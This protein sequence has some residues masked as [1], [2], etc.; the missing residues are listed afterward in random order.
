MPKNEKTE[1]LLVIPHPTNYIDIDMSE[2]EIEKEVRHQIVNALQPVLGEFKITSELT[3]HGRGVDWFTITATLSFVGAIF[4]GVPKLYE[5]F[6]TWK[7]ISTKFIA[8]L[9]K[10]KNKYNSV[11]IS[12]QCVPML[13]STIIE[14]SSKNS[15]FDLVSV[16]EIPGFGHNSPVPPKV[17]AEA[18]FIVV[19]REL[20]DDRDIIHTFVLSSQGD[21]QVYNTVKRSHFD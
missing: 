1:L 5:A 19:I 4:F 15:R 3:D 12:K 20:L 17:D 2:V 11:F 6:V 13:C 21:V 14:P 7:E 10:L 18:L 8:G 16:I 9:R